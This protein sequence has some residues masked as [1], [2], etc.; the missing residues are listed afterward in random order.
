MHS[1]RTIFG[2]NHSN[3]I[4]KLYLILSGIAFHSCRPGQTGME[5]VSKITDPIIVDASDML[6]HLA[7]DHN[8]CDMNQF[9][10][11]WLFNNSAIELG[12]GFGR[13][14]RRNTQTKVYIPE[15]GSYNLFVRM[16]GRKGNSFRIAIGEQ[17]SPL[18]TSD[19]ILAW[20]PAGKMELEKGE[21][22]LLLTRTNGYLVFDVLVL[23]RDERLEEESLIEYQYK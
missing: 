5:E 22:T 3:W 15:S 21:T 19:S 9:E 11:Q 20:H 17:T 2:I 8:Y 6:D 14:A 10:G 4:F 13:T 16:G 12:K 7:M 18:V 23:A 1:D